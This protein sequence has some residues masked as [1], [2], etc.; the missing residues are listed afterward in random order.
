MNYIDH[1]N[2]GNRF[3]QL[4]NLKE[5][6]QSY[7][8]AISIWPRFVNAIF[9]RQ[10]CFR[11]L[12]QFPEAKK[13]LDSILEMTQ[14]LKVQERFYP[15]LDLRANTLLHTGVWHAEQQQWEQAIPFYKKSLHLMLKLPNTFNMGLNLIKNYYNQGLV[16]HELKNNDQAIEAY[17]NG[18]ALAKFWEEN[19]KNSIMLELQNIGY[20]HRGKIFGIVK[21]FEKAKN[22]FKNLPEAHFLIGEMYF[23]SGVLYSA[24]TYFERCLDQRNLGYE[25]QDL[26][27]IKSAYYLNGLNLSKRIM[28]C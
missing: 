10:V 23:K 13:D 14:N 25:H 27:Q 26:I 28:V 15:L 18:I 9:R 5:A 3:E 8:Q 7:N 20:L 24:R 2:Y 22:D 6:I 17:T 11:Q 16:F 19:S 12:N 21:E 4:G 1:Y